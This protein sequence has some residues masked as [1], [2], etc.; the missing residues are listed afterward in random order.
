MGSG[1]TGYVC[2]I[3]DRQW[4]GIELN[5]KYCDLARKRINQEALKPKLF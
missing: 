1:T 4:I 2:E 5:P 3:L